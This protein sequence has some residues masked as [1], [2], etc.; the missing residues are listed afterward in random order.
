LGREDSRGSSGKTK[1]HVYRA[2]Q[3]TIADRGR[4]KNLDVKTALPLSYTS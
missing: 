2:D 1:K 3:S 4:G